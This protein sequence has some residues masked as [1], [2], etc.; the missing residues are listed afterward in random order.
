MENIV[1]VIFMALVTYIPRLIPMVFLNN[2]QLSP[3]WKRFLYFIPFAA[4][5]ALIF[6]DILYS[7]G[8]MNSAIIGGIISVVL[9]FLD[10]NVVFVVFGGIIAALLFKI[11]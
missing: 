2:K 1:I 3:F 9:S 4:L 7:T 8:D 10:L 11:V 6:P 5:S